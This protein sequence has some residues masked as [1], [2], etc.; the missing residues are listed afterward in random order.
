MMIPI[1]PKSDSPNDLLGGTLKT[2]PNSEATR[3]FRMGK[4][5]KDGSARMPEG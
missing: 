4:R 1:N 5:L 3:D 2:I